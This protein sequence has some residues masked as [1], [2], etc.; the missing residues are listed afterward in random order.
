[1]RCAAPVAMLLVL[2]A[3][4]RAQSAIDGLELV[5]SGL[6]SPMFVTY[7][8]GD[9]NRLFIAERSGAIRTLNLTTGAISPFLNMTGINVTGEGGFL[10]L[11][12]HPQYNTA[13]SPHFGKFYVN[14]TTTGSPLTTHIREFKSPANA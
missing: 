1:M 12:F 13:G 8:P 3:A 9:A 10:G 4:H 6:N 14:V 2:F 7:A 5:A 11:A